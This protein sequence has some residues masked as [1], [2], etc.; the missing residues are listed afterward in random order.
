MCGGGG[1][2]KGR[3]D[4]LISNS[5]ENLADKCFQFGQFIILSSVV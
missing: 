4:S 5:I 3:G 2:G 1:E